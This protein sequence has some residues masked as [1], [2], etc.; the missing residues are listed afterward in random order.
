MQLDERT[1]RWS[2][3]VGGAV[4]FVAAVVVPLLRQE[5]TRM[6][7]TV[8]A[9]DGAIYYG[10]VAFDGAST[11]FRGNDGYL[12]FV[13]RLLMMPAAAVPVE[14]VS[15]YITVTAAVCTALLAVFVY[16]CTEGW[17]ATVPFRLL[18]AG[19]Y[20]LAPAAA[21][22]TTGNFTNLIWP[23][24][25]AAPWALLSQ[26]DSVPDVVARSAVLVLAAL[27]HV[28]A[29]LFV[30]LALLMAVRRRRLDVYMTA[31]ALIVAL[32]AQA[33]FMA[34]A[35]ER[36]TS[37]ASSVGELYTTV[38]VNVLGSFL[39]G[40]R[41]I[42][43][44]WVDHGMVAAVAFTAATAA[45][46]LVLLWRAADPAR[47]V[48]LVLVVYAALVA[49]APLWSNGTA[50]T[51]PPAGLPPVPVQRYVVVPVMLLIGAAAV[52][53]DAPGRARTRPEAKVGRPLL[54]AHSILVLLLSF[55]IVNPRS[56]GPRWPD[57]VEEGRRTCA[58]GEEVAGL[59]ITPGGWFTVLPC[60]ELGG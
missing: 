15:V 54:L 3:R 49:G 39:L 48:A 36:H 5:G 60:D 42:S 12:Q 34:V 27:S 8:W 7:R 41:P 52:L 44:L 24:L 57:E 58:A 53:V 1:R 18:V 47:R 23:L 45:V 4:L 26:R 17:I 2:L 33:G 11:L 30:P 59:D 14:S 28:L 29:V 6:W 55:S 9:E 50:G 46:F 20:V 40:E 32:V 10:G 13:P 21:W 56:N 38:S 19:A 31:A 51:V 16:R 43:D 35:P 22:E 37:T 25:G